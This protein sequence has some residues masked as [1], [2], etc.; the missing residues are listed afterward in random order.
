MGEIDEALAALLAVVA[1]EDPAVSAPLVFAVLVEL[2]TDERAILAAA[3]R[4]YSAGKGSRHDDVSAAPPGAARLAG[5]PD[6][7]GG[8][9]P[10]R[11]LARREVPATAPVA[12]I[13]AGG[14]RGTHPPAQAAR[15]S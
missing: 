11:G 4:I 10:R 3:W 9:H 5:G 15:A 8:A 7:R 2:S 1:D 12:G 13:R 6:A 14:L